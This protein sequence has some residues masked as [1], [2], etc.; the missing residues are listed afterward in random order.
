MQ[1]RKDTKG[2][3]QIKSKQRGGR[4]KLNVPVSTFSV[5]RLASSIEMNGYGKKCY[6]NSSQERTGCFYINTFLK[7]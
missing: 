3:K 6:A 2:M 7:S 4:F 5:I 1:A